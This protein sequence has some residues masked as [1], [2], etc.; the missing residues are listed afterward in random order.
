V[1]LDR[2]LG[3]LSERNFRLYF[4]GQMTSSVGTS[5]TPV[6]LSFAVLASDH[7]ASD[8]GY[9]LTAGTVPLVVFLLIG[10]VLADRLGRRRVM[11][12]S[13]VTRA[14]AQSGLA[15]WVLAGHVPL[16]GFMALSAM[17]G[18]GEAFFAPSM[19]GL[20]PEVVSAHRLPQANALNGL[21]NSIGGVIGP[22]IAGVIVAAASPGWAIAGDALSYVVSVVSLALLQLPPGLAR[23]AESY[24]HQLRAG[25]MGFWSRTWLWAIVL[26]WSVGNAVLFAPYLVLGAVISKTTLGGATAWGTILAAQGAG[27]LFGGLVMLRLRFPRPLFAGSATAVLFVAPL[28]SLAYSRS[29]PL[30]A[31]CAFLGGI[32]LATFMAIWDTTMQREIPAEMLSRLSAYDWFGSLVFLPVGYAIVGPVSHLIGIRTTFLVGCAYVLISTAAVICIP[33]VRQLRWAESSPAAVAPAK[34]DAS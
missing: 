12:A 29:V 20:I 30:I 25:W 28:L 26:Q 4:V 3:A 27:A 24:W 9:V 2:W 14:A 33:T 7:S 6:A 18:T 19:I 10:G 15:I 13:D 1:R 31:A 8:L 23:A 22:S 16:W 34:R 17:V 21:T 11:L 32:Q 5:M